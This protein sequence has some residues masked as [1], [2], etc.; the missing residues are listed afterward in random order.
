MFH[1]TAPEG[2]S[3]VH[4]KHTVQ[5]GTH[6]AEHADTDNNN[7]NQNKATET[8]QGPPAATSGVFDF[9][10]RTVKSPAK[11]EKKYKS[12][13]PQVAV[14]SVGCCRNGLITK[15]PNINPVG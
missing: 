14:S 10:Y 13:A 7:S 8:K 12:G 3:S 6:T 2:R 1:R 11:Q 15:H 5:A 4:C 9:V